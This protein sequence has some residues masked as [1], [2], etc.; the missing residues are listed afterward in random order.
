MAAEPKAATEEAKID[1]FEDDDEFEEF[2]INEGKRIY[3]YIYR[4]KFDLNIRYLLYVNK[5]SYCFL[6]LIEAPWSPLDDLYLGQ[7]SCC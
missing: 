7:N 4:S 2:E 5:F 1:L 6:K 3:I